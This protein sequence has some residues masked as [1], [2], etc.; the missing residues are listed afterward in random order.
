VEQLYTMPAPEGTS[1][2]VVHQ[3]H[4]REPGK[5]EPS[6][7]RDLSKTQNE[8]VAKGQLA[9]HPKRTQQTGTILK[10]SHRTPSIS[11]RFFRGRSGID[12]SKCSTR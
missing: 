7:G 5:P 4:L 10:G 6:L 3:L 12:D 9:L 2:N 8:M 1:E 11:R